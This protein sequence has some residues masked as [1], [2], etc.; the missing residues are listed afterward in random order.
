[1][2]IEPKVELTEETATQAVF[3]Y[4]TKEEIWQSKPRTTIQFP[5]IAHTHVAKSEEQ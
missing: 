4:Y 1:V 2:L 3:I 5:E